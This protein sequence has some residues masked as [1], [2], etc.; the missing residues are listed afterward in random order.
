[1]TRTRT[2]LTWTSVSAPDFSSASTI[3]SNAIQQFDNAGKSIMGAF[4]GLDKSQQEQANNIVAQRMLQYM[5]DPEGMKQLAASGDYAQGIHERYVNP[6]LVMEGFSDAQKH[7]KA[8]ADISSTQANINKTNLEFDKLVE[9][10]SNRKEFND[11]LKNNIGTYSTLT[12]AAYSGDIAK[13]GSLISSIDNP[14]VAKTLMGSFSPENLKTAVSANETFSKYDDS[15]EQS[16]ALDTLIKTKNQMSLLSGTEA[17]RSNF[18]AQRIQEASQSNNKYLQQGYLDLYQK[19]FGRPYQ[20]S[21]PQEPITN[22]G[23]ETLPNVSQNIDAKFGANTSNHNWYA[24]YGDTSNSPKQLPLGQNSTIGDAINASINKRHTNDKG[25][26][27]NSAV[28]FAQFLPGTLKDAIKLH[29]AAVDSGQVKAPKYDEQTVFSPEVQ[30]NLA[31]Q[32]IQRR[33]NSKDTNFADM[34][35]EWPSLSQIEGANE[36]GAFKDISPDTLLGIVSQLESRGIQVLPNK[37]KEQKWTMQDVKALD[38]VRQLNE[39]NIDFSNYEKAK[40]EL[41]NIPKTM[42]QEVY[43]RR[44]G[45]RT[46]PK[47]DRKTGKRLTETYEYGDPVRQ[48]KTVENPN[49]VAAQKALDSQEKSLIERQGK[50]SR[51][52]FEDTVASGNINA[53]TGHLDT[54]IKLLQDKLGEY[55]G[56]PAVT[57]FNSNVEDSKKRE[58]ASSFASLNKHGVGELTKQIASYLPNLNKKGED[59]THSELLGEIGK[60]YGKVKSSSQFKDKQVP[61]KLIGLAILQNIG[62]DR[63]LTPD[64]ITSGVGV[65]ADDV[66]KTVASMMNSGGKKTEYLAEQRRLEGLVD[67]RKALDS[68]LLTITATSGRIQD[69]ASNKA[70]YSRI[71]TNA[72]KALPFLRGDLKELGSRKG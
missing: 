6:S 39:F 28:G 10:A 65:S 26:T 49:F 19:T 70:A 8:T 23:S 12:K 33:L 48:V 20:I 46:L 17:D 3:L 27:N 60:I 58:A 53:I 72:L 51:T 14:I 71:R 11:W 13:V 31:R 24:M 43:E 18:L 45:V 34:T 54:E 67:V 15:Q 56:D 5:D 59:G 50:L 35:K 62:P 42:Q 1:M 2:P 9:D 37:P 7:M 4:D 41:G 40:A 21:I 47:Y 32:L 69:A 36:V 44:K 29:N 30:I 66:I 64:M 52:A 57:I 55:G 16:L 63:W 61:D 38:R 25:E 22:I 68:D